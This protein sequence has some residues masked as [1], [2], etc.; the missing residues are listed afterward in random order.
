MRERVRRAEPDPPSG[1]GPEQVDQA[2]DRRPVEEDGP[3]R[4]EIVA[5]GREHV[6]KVG[7]AFAPVATQEGGDLGVGRGRRAGAREQPLRAVDQRAHGA[8]QRV[9]G[10]HVRE[11]GLREAGMIL[12]VFAHARQVVNHGNVE[13]AQMRRRPRRPRA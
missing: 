12:E 13:F 7:S 4:R 10:R 6:L 2:R 3:V 9:V 1:V 8:H 5:G 11:A